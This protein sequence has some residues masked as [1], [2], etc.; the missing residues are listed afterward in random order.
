MDLFAREQQVYKT[1]VAELRSAD[2]T[3]PSTAKF[4][5]ITEEYGKL[6]KQFQQYRQMTGESERKKEF[7]IP[8]RIE[9]ISDSHYDMLTG[10]FNRKYLQDNMER[11]LSTMGR[12]GD[13]LSLIKI[14]IDNLNQYND[15]Y[16]HNAGDECIRYVAKTLKSCL[17]R[18]QDFVA[19]SAGE[20]FMAVLPHTPE[21]GSRLVAERMLE[22]VRALKIPHSENDI[23]NYVT[24][25]I[26][27]VTS[28]KNPGDQSPDDFFNRA[29]EALALA[30][31]GGR[32]KYSFLELSDL[33]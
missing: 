33:A 23:S 1:A 17:F 20:E 7:I 9:T 5:K 11:V 3:S 21:D 16:G 29:E 28:S 22:E 12:Q 2:T 19:R 8:E 27:L 6:L 32:N 13:I 18:A 30:K 4:A 10:V 15:I 24:V 25:S 14:D 26:G 31:S